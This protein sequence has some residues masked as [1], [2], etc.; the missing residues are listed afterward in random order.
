ME[1]IWPLNAGNVGKIL[2]I[3]RILRTFRFTFD[4]AVIAPNLPG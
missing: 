3:W 1:N 4:M 2:R